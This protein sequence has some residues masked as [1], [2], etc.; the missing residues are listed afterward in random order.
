MG[1]SFVMLNLIT[2]IFFDLTFSTI[3]DTK[4]RELVHQVKELFLQS[5]VDR[6]GKISFKEFQRQVH[7]PIFETYFKVIDLDP[8]EARGLFD[9]L[10]TDGDDEVEAQ[11]FVMGCLRLRG[12]ARAIDL[13]TL[14]HDT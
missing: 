11:D 10:D 5:D 12:P 4:D 14:T 2:G 7:N 1:A 3:R 8:S 6:S 9:L 13:A